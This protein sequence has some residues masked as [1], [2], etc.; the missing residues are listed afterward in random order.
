MVLQRGCNWI[1]RSGGSR[2]NS[3]IPQCLI[4][5]R[6][7]RLVNKD[8]PGWLQSTGVFPFTAVSD[9]QGWVLETQVDAPKQIFVSQH[10]AVHPLTDHLRQPM[11][12]ITRVTSIPESSRRSA[13]VT[14]VADRLRAVA[15]LPHRN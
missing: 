7:K 13:L 4:Q 1:N 8:L 11:G 5:V 12:D 6:G 10:Q 2:W 15:R 9:G 14:S 3:S